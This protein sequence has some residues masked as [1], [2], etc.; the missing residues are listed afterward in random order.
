MKYL[1]NKKREEKQH[2]LWLPDYPGYPILQHYIVQAD[3][4]NPDIS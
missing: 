2:D 3:R 1:K 4:T